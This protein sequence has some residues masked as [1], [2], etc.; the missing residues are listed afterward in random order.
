MTRAPPT[1]SLRALLRY[2]LQL[3]GDARVPPRA[4]LDPVVDAPRL[5]ANLALLRIDPAPPVFRVVGSD[6]VRWAKRDLTGRVIDERSFPGEAA[7]MCKQLGFVASERRPLGFTVGYGPLRSIAR[8]VIGLPFAEPDGRV[9]DILVGV[10]FDGHEGDFSDL[11]APQ[12]EEI[13]VVSLL[14]ELQRT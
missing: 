2:W 11:P 7:R 12:T 1:E 14:R 3:R 9:R 8:S 5:V 6:I 13:D 4:K 10:F